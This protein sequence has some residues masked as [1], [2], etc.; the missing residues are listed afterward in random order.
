MFIYLLYQFHFWLV[1]F[2]WR[3]WRG[4]VRRFYDNDNGN[5]DIFFTACLNHN[6]PDIADCILCSS[7]S[8]SI[9]VR[10]TVTVQFKSRIGEAS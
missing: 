3:G 6:I 9:L 2:D 8:I 7:I 10:S 1:P 4:G 5:L